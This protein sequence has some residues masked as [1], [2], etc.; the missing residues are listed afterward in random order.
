MKNKRNILIILLSMILICCAGTVCAAD[1]NNTVDIVS[2]VDSKEEYISVSDNEQ[3]D[4]V[5]E[6]VLSTQNEKSCRNFNV[7]SDN[8][9]LSVSNEDSLGVTTQET[10]QYL[11]DIKTSTSDE[12]YKFVDYLIKQKG[13]KFNAKNSNDG[14]TIYSSSNYQSKLYDGENYVLPAGTQYFISKDRMAYVLDD[15][16]PD[17][18]YIQNGNTYVDEIYLGWLKNV[19]NYHLILN[20]DESNDLVPIIPT[21]SSSQSS[22]S[23]LPPVYDLRNV[24]GKNYLTPV[25]HQKGGNTCWAFASIAALESFLLKSEGKTYDFSTNYD[26][27]ENNLKNVMSNIGRQGMDYVFVNEGGFGSVALAY[28]LRWSGPISD[29]LD[30]YITDN[31]GHVISNNPI[32]FNNS[33]KHVQ[34]VKYINRYNGLL[35]Y[36]EI[37]QTIMD[38]G[39]FVTSMWMIN[40]Y[41]YLN[42]VNYYYFGNADEKD[43][44]GNKLN[45]AHAICIVGWDDNYSKDNFL[46]KPEKDGAFIVRNSWGSEWGDGGYFYMS[47]CDTKLAFQNYHELSDAVGFVFT[48]VQD[49]TNYDKNYHYTPLGSIFWPDS[50]QKSIKYRNNYISSSDEILKA[51]GVYVNCPVTCDIEVFVNDEVKSVAKQKIQLNYAGFHTIN[52]DSPTK[53]TKGQKFRVEVALQSSTN[54]KYPLECIIKYS[55]DEIRYSGASSN[56]GESEFYENGIW[57]D[58]TTKYPDANL[59]LNAYTD[60]YPIPT[61][62]DVSDLTMNAGENRNI[63]ATLYDIKDNKIK[64][65]QI[66]ISING[67][68]VISVTND[69]GQVSFPFTMSVGVYSVNFNFNG[70]D[71]YVGVSKIITVTVN[72]VIVQVPPQPEPTVNPPVIPS[73]PVITKPDSIGKVFKLNGIES[74]KYSANKKFKLD[75]DPN[76]NLKV[77]LYINSKTEK[78]SFDNGKCTLKLGNYNYLKKNKEYKF[79]FTG[80]KNNYVLDKSVKIKI[81]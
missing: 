72:Q 66:T 55:D 29:E 68:T 79:R 56:F 1:S 61:R 44:Q 69:N 78:L 4:N 35:D 12:F 8:E 53:L 13:F 50:N 59:C 31:T 63:V 40:Q 64:N 37:K 27:S 62:F 16:Y 80:S 2:D 17:M 38:Y 65:A 51:C 14:Y 36:N 71:M 30:K 23:N 77:S 39:P 18:L 28:F 58:I 60:Y 54:L 76:A 32:E 42:G 22:S 9:I 41:P 81:V 3:A 11:N 7:T 19:E 73:D 43:A 57:K 15:Y 33:E 20:V 74:G 10:N 46:I 75:L 21:Q 45:F 48:S 34:G 47:Y 24:N 49:K 26:F 52:F 25:K 5:D 70:N 6:S 67:V